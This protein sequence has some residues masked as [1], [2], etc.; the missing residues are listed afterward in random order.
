[1][2]LENEPSVSEITI[3]APNLHQIPQKDLLQKLGE[4]FENDIYLPT[5]DPSGTIMVTVGR[6][7]GEVVGS[8]QQG[9]MVDAEAVKA[10]IRTAL[11]NMKSNACPMAMRVAWH[12][13]GTWDKV[14][15]TGGSDGATMR[16]QP[17][18]TDGANA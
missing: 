17:E 8:T 10:D 3:N 12:S 18:F 14:T 11:I 7:A 2:V 1:M 4:K 9:A 5:S 6:E 15:G 16:F 13:A